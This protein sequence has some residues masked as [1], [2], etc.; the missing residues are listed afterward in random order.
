MDI[1]IRLA[2]VADITAC[3]QITYAAFKQI[4]EL[5]GFNNIEFPTPDA[6]CQYVDLVIGNPFYYNMVAELNGRIIGLCV[7]DEH[8]SIKG[9]ELVS[10]DPGAQGQGVGRK[11]MEAALERSRGSRGVRLIQHIFNTTSL[12]LY[13]S[14]GFEVKE[15]LLLMH[16]LPSNQ[17]PAD[18]EVR[19]MR[20]N[21][22][23]ECGALF[24]KINGFS[25]VIELRQLSQFFSPFVAVRASHIVAYAASPAMPP[26]NHVVSE[27]ENDMQAL[28][29]GIAFAMADPLVVM[30]PIRQASLFR[31]CLKQNLRA[32][33]P[34]SL[35]V[36]GEYQEPKGTYLPSISF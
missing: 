22:L 29:L 24:E 9:V 14:L 3:G 4:N 31:W 34:Y 12:S 18:V 5:H 35:M 27:T 36:L 11:L 7:L 21:E 8:S 1:N 13:S 26:N 30:L 15:P 2:T 23:D 19:P 32:I 20:D 10:V 6:A 17:P 28:L 25:R 33:K 16:G